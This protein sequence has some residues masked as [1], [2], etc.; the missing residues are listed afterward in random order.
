MA[1]QITKEQKTSADQHIGECI[2]FNESDFKYNTLLY[3]NRIIPAVNNVI[4][5]YLALTIKHKPFDKDFLVDLDLNGFVTIENEYRQYSE[6]AID[7][8]GFPGKA[9]KEKLMSEVDSDLLPL[10]KAIENLKT[11]QQE[12]AYHSSV[13]NRIAS[14]EFL[15]IQQD[16]AVLSDSGKEQLKNLYSVFIDTPEEAELWDAFQQL[17]MNFD[18]FCDRLTTVGYKLHHNLNPLF[19]NRNGSSLLFQD[20]KNCLGIRLENF[21]QLKSLI[22]KKKISDAKS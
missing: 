3:Q 22:A 13:K 19:E 8:I 1:R 2:F 21:A 10:K 12:I 14:L 16:K 17:K 18:N 9:A 11:I 5:E 4:K 7:K 6:T 20:E 15:E